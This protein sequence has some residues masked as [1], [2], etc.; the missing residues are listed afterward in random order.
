MPRNRRCFIHNTL[1]EIC[2]RTE[3]GLPL[4]ATRYMKLLIEGIFAR[5]AAVYPVT[6]CGMVVM[7]NHIHLLVVVDTPEHVP[8]FVA[9]VKREIAHIVNR[10]KG[11]VGQTVW[12]DG[13]DAVIILDPEK[14]IE[15][16]VYI[17]TNP[18]KANLVRTIEEYP[19]ICS[20]NDFLLGGTEVQCKRIARDKIPRLSKQS[21]SLK[22]QEK[23][24]DGLN[25]AASGEVMLY[26]QPDA[27]MSCFP[28][29]QTANPEHFKNEIIH[30]VRKEERRLMQERKY[31][32]MGAI[33]LQLENIHKS[34]SPKKRS[35][36]MLCMSTLIER[37]KT[38]IGWCRQLFS[39]GALIFQKWKTGDYTLLLPPGLFAPGGFLLANLLPAIVVIF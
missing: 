39:E 34:F 15:R 29:L 9:Y 16:F 22:A 25:E 23:L 31:P 7:G 5:A 37:R 14:A 27:W 13:Y 26:I 1:I 8:L 38:F 4:V 19:N 10:L 12:Q 3:A 36:R 28:E 20:W 30:K 32:V 21:L 18:Q 33:A 17:Y 2:F 24:F 11:N 6:I 35:R